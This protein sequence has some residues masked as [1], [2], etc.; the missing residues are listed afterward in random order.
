MNLQTPMPP[1]NRGEVLM[2]LITQCGLITDGTM[3]ISARDAGRPFITCKE[4]VKSAGYTLIGEEARQNQ[5]MMPL[6]APCA[7]R[8]ADTQ[9]IILLFAL[10]A[11]I[12][13]DVKSW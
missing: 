5:T 4:N 2:S 3:Y 9:R 11:V 13:G 10:T 6:S 8:F 7:A 12:R 1:L